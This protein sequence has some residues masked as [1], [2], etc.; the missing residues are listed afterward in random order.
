MSIGQSSNLQ[1][2]HLGHVVSGCRRRR[3]EPGACWSAGLLCR[4]GLL[5]LRLDTVGRWLEDRLLG[6]VT[7]ILE[8]TQ[9]CQ[10]CQAIS[11]L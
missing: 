7:S 8:P 11:C 10:T 4:R 5:G 1:W 3:E 9:P 6:V 2:A